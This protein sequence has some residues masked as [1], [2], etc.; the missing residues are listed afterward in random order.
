ME[1]RWMAEILVV[2]VDYDIAS[3]YERMKSSARVAAS[4][5]F[6]LSNVHFELGIVEFLRKGADGFA[7]LQQ[8]R[9]HGILAA[10][11]RPDVISFVGIRISE[12]NSV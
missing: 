11:V 9:S 12:Q 3:V 6:L 8:Y 10:R 1:G 7:I 5:R 4:Q 2:A